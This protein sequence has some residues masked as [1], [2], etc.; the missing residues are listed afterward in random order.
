ML[1]ISIKFNFMTEIKTIE[2]FSEINYYNKYNGRS[3]S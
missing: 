3:I 1:N 2:F